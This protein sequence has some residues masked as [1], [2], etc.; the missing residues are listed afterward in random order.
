MASPI[1]PLG[2][3]RGA[4]K[5][6]LEL[7]PP[8]D[9]SL[10]EYAV[11]LM[12]RAGKPLYPWQ[13]D[14]CE[15]MMA[16]RDGHW[17]CT[18]YAEWVAR[19]N[20]KGALLEA[21]ALAGFFLFDEELISW[22][23]HEYKTAMEAFR[24]VRALIRA[25]G[26]PVSG[27][28]INLVTVDGI[29]VKINNTNGEESFERLDTEAR[30]KFIARSKGSGRGFTGDCQ[31]IDEAFAYTDLHQEA[32][33]PTTLATK[34]EQ[35]LYMSTPPLDGV[36]A[37]PMY[38]LRARADAGGDDSLGYRDW[39]IGGILEESA[40]VDVKDRALSAAACPSLGHGRI[41]EERLTKLR[42]KLGR[43]GYLREVLGV[44][45][46]QVMVSG[47]GI[48][49]D[50]WRS[51]GDEDSVIAGVPA[52]GIDMPWDRS[53]V[54]IA[55][56]GLREDKKRHVEIIHS[57]PGVDWVIPFMTERAKRWQ[58]CVI[59]IDGNGPAGALIP[60]LE[61]ALAQIGAEVI[62]VGGPEMAGACGCFYDDATQDNLRHLSD[63]LL[64][65][66]LAGA[67]RSD[68][69][70]VWHWDRKDST[71]NISPLVAVTL[72]RHGRVVYGV[73][74]ELKNSFW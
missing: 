42:R 25:L 60:E 36:A 73:D 18:D 40:E 72:A 38:A 63:P 74:Y 5:P 69:G 59:L 58:P 24:R 55:A 22:S 66:A 33:A 61:K 10:G 8:Y 51:L 28:N 70:D 26:D 23:A 30:I 17:A 13:V 68:R 44:W 45:P 47:G 46:R 43:T 2:S 52:F 50:T 34:D 48:S 16:V 3:L 56:A 19:Q 39:G 32:L 6:R 64:Q 27:K 31:I 37:G 62:K 11:E 14:S 4:A 71:A 15:L 1:S 21:R 41:T 67:V 53:S 12:A 35:T 54:S 9:Y 57:Q 49:L 20:G 29:P 65:T 7:A